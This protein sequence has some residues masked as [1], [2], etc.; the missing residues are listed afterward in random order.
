MAGGNGHE[1]ISDIQW[2]NDTTGQV[3]ISSRDQIVDFIDKAGETALYCPDRN[4]GPAAW[5]RVNSNGRVRYP[6]TYADGRW[7]NNLLALPEV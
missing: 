5:V 3:G 7:T 4:N 2:Q 1:Y 6:Q